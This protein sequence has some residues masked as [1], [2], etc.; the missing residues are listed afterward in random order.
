LGDQSSGVGLDFI[1]HDTHADSTLLGP[2]FPHGSASEREAEDEMGLSS[3]LPGLDPFDPM[4]TT[5]VIEG[6]PGADCWNDISS[7]FLALNPPLEADLNAVPGQPEMTHQNT[8]RFKETR[9]SRNHEV[10]LQNSAS[11]INQTHSSSSKLDNVLT[12]KDLMNQRLSLEDILVAGIRAL[13]EE[14]QHQKEEMSSSASPLNLEGNPQ[15]SRFSSYTTSLEQTPLAEIHM[16]TIQLTTMSFVAACLANAA[17]IDLSPEALF[18]STS[19]SPFYQMQTTKTGRLAH[20]KPLLQPSSTQLENPHHPYL[21]ILPFPSFR[22]RTIQLLQIQPP[23][24]DPAQLCQDLKNDGIICWGSTRRNKRDSNGSGVPWDIRS[25]E[26]R[27]WFLQKWWI[28]FDG[29][30]GEMYQHSRW[31]CELRGERSSFPW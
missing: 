17:M 28:L 12:S 20:V 9:P 10:N 19:Q 15:Q 24:F 25:W 13:S 31:W 4:T 27:P 16:N 21:D 14:N 5:S 30:D 22:N 7:I 26:V 18:D 2:P 11:T 1:N 23:P 6:Q 29:P 8:N 3:Y